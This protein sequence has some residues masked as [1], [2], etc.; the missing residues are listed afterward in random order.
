MQRSRAI[1]FK[2]LVSPV[3]NKKMRCKNPQLS[4]NFTADRT[5]NSLHNINSLAFQK[6]L[7]KP[8]LVNRIK[9]DTTLFS[10]HQNHSK[11]CYKVASIL[12]LFKNLQIFK[13]TGAVQ[14]NYSIDK[15]TGY[16]Q[17]KKVLDSLHRLLPDNIQFISYIAWVS[18]PNIIDDVKPAKFNENIKSYQHKIVNKKVFINFSSDDHSKGYQRKFKYLCQIDSIDY[19]RVHFKLVEQRHLNI[20]QNIQKLKG[21]KKVYFYFEHFQDNNP[22]L[23]LQLLKPLETL[24]LTNIIFDILSCSNF[25]NNS[26]FINNLLKSLAKIISLQEISINAKNIHQS[27]LQ[28][29]DILKPSSSPFP[30]LQ[31]F[32]VHH[33]SITTPPNTLYYNKILHNMFDIKKLISLE[34]YPLFIGDY[35]KDVQLLIQSLGQCNQITSLLIGFS[36][37]SNINQIMQDLNC[38]LIDMRALEK[39][40]IIN[41]AMTTLDI[42]I[43]KQTLNIMYN[44]PLVNVL[45]LIVLPNISVILMDIIKRNRHIKSLFL[46]FNMVLGPDNIGDLIKLIDKIKMK[47]AKIEHLSVSFTGIQSNQICVISK[48]A[49]KLRKYNFDYLQVVSKSSSLL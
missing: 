20:L 19:V 26:C 34:I 41:R 16:D 28:L 27:Q 7:T 5:I 40:K 44:K 12:K 9:I 31:S 46:S 45:H 30:N 4:I 38:S 21:L 15:F 39:V 43:Y 32:K 42:E 23:L 33:L 49:L 10:Q 29:E 24:N 3:K 48:K 25:E 6:I 1:P 37:T 18:T 14:A 22:N 2:M 36:C 8:N 47:F 11:L 13:M 17:I 35:H